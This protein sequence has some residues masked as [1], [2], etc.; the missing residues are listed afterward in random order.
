MLELYDCRALESVTTLPPDLRTLT[1]RKCK[2]LKSLGSAWP[3]K[4]ASVTLEHVP[5]LD[6]LPADTWPLSIRCVVINHPGKTLQVPEFTGVVNGLC[7][8]RKLWLGN[9]R[10][11]FCV[12]PI[13]YGLEELTVVNC[14]KA[15]WPQDPGAPVTKVLTLLM[16]DHCDQLAVNN[17]LMRRMPALETVSMVAARVESLDF[18]Y[19]LPKITHLDISNIKIGRPRGGWSPC[20]PATFTG[21]S[22]L[23]SLVYTTHEEELVQCYVQPHAPAFDSRTVISHKAVAG[24]ADSKAPVVVLDEKKNA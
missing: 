18:L 16:L 15:T 5:S 6:V 4:L 8:A 12:P 24:P 1:V 22:K 21:F 19:W 20:V 14:A 3:Q 13:P 17:E 10:G 9:F 2:Q 11:A 7:R 23:Q